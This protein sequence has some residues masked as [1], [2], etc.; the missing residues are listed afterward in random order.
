M[1]PVSP[2]QQVG[3]VCN[4]AEKYTAILVRSSIHL[5]IIPTNYVDDVR[6]ANDKIKRGTRFDNEEQKLLFKE[7]WK[8]EDDAMDQ[9]D[10]KRMGVVCL[11][12]MNSIEDD[13]TFTVETQEDFVNKRVQTLD[14]ETWFDAQEGVVR[15]SFFEKE[16]RTPLVIMERSA[17]G[18][19]QKHSILAN[20]LVRRLSNLDQSMGIADQV[21]VINKYTYK[22]KASGYSRDQAKEIVVSGLRGFKNKIRRRIREGQ[23]FY[24]PAR[25]TLSMRV[26]KKLTEKNTWYKKTGRKKGEDGDSDNVMPV[27]TRGSYRGTKRKKHQNHNHILDKVEEERKQHDDPKSEVKSVIFVPQTKHSELAKK[28][29]ECENELVKVTGYKIKIVERCGTS[30]TRILTKSNPWGG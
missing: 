24:R 26:R 11:E 29:R 8:T 14:F 4:W 13:L 21:E 27:G 12:V 20:D 7:E 30:L 16:M 25:K 3:C 17:L 1:V 15:H 9:T 6:Q 28:L 2:W 5:Y 18:N 22:L 23:P 19:Q 10:L